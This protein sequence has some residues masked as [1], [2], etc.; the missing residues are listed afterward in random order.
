MKKYLF[1]ISIFFLMP[2]FVYASNSATI[3]V[4]SSKE[5]VS[6]GDTVTALGDYAGHLLG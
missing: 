3:N 4:T 5:N 2:S 1:L 6:V